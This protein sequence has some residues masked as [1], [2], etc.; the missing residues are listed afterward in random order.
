MEQNA[1]YILSENLQ[2]MSAR[3]GL[4]LAGWHPKKDMAAQAVDWWLWGTFPV[5]S[6]LHRDNVKLKYPRFR[7]RRSPRT[8][9]PRLRRRRLQPNI[10]PVQR[11]RPLRHRPTRLQRAPKRHRIDLPPIRR[12]SPPAQHNRNKYILLLHRRHNHQ[13]GRHL[14]NCR[15]R[16]LNLQSRRLAKRRRSLRA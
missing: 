12:P 5:L 2:D 6:Q 7:S 11:Q 9:L 15:L 8:K 1:G 14:Y 13:R 3:S 10:L 4:S 16:P